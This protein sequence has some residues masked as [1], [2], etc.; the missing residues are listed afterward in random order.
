MNV[1]SF[2]HSSK[3]KFESTTLQLKEQDLKDLRFAFKNI[4]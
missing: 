3:S 4:F 2:N 1:I